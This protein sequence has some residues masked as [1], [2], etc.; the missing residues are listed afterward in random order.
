M[1]NKYDFEET[2]MEPS[3]DLINYALASG[4][5]KSEAYS[6]FKKHPEFIGCEKDLDKLHELGETLEEEKLQISKGYRADHTDIFEEDEESGSNNP[7]YEGY[8][9]DELNIVDASHKIVN[10]WLCQALDKNDGAM[11][12]NACIVLKAIERKASEDWKYFGVTVTPKMLDEKD[13]E[14]YD[15]T[16]LEDD[17]H[18]ERQIE[19]MEA[20]GKLYDDLENIFRNLVDNNPNVEWDWFDSGEVSPFFGSLYIKFA[21]KPE[22]YDNFKKL[23]EQTIKDN[24]LIDTASYGTYGSE[25]VEW[26]KKG[27]YL[28]QEEY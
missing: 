12:R 8:S 16:K 25:D 10:K 15:N 28:E 9:E 23:V 18:T 5:N 26:I 20:Q 14:K 3:Q 27:K 19:K 1:T 17:S 21:V 7:D 11:V 4:F 24:D 6:F 13:F 22:E 2:T